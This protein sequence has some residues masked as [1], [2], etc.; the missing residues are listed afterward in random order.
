[1]KD[2]R[3]KNRLNLLAHADL[4]RLG[5]NPIE[6]LVEVYR[7]AMTAYR[8]GRGITEKGDN[9]AQFLAVAGKAAVDLAKF[10]HPTLSAIAV[11]DVSENNSDKE[12]LTTREAI[13]V[14]KSDPFA[15][16][17][18]KNIPTDRIVEAMNSSIQSP[19][20]PTGQKTSDEK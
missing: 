7:E 18:I 6:M 4:D 19:L 10:K 2:H 14:I 8:A 17:E 1:M 20:L 12:P 5:A 16:K 9:G 13:D 15:P 11:K 3:R